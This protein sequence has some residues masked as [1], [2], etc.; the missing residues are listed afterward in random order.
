MNGKYIEGKRLTDVLSVAISE[1][2][3]MYGNYVKLNIEGANYRIDN[4]IGYGE[5]KNAWDAR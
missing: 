2:G 3:R 4:G 1:N 5:R